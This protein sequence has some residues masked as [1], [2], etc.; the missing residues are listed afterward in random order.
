MRFQCHLD[1]PR[2]SILTTVGIDE[3]GFCKTDS[4]IVKHRRLMEIAKGCEIILAH[5]DV[6]IPK[7]RQSFWINRI[8]QLLWMR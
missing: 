5:K 6:R 1:T 2:I 7:R 8:F 3:F 4:E